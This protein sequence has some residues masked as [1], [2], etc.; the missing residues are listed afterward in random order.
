LPSPGL[1]RPAV[2]RPNGLPGR[3]SPP[4]FLSYPLFSFPFQV[5]GTYLLSPISSPHRSPSSPARAFQNPL[6]LPNSTARRAPKKHQD[7]AAKLFV[8]YAWGDTSPT[9]SEEDRQ[10]QE[11]VERLCRTLEQEH[12][13]VIR[14]KTTLKY[15]DPISDFMKTDACSSSRLGEPSFLDCWH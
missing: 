7:R 1:K 11:V 2:R 9:A 4:L 3:E 5:P 15:G 6:S 12:W 8:S 10:R 13:Q 14:D